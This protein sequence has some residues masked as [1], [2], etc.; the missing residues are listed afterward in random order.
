MQYSVDESLFVLVHRFPSTQMTIT[1]L[2]VSVR[3]CLCINE[4]IERAYE[5]KKKKEKERDIITGTEKNKQ[6][7]ERACLI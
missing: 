7:K 5:R 2:T 1:P 6:T 3:F 4:K